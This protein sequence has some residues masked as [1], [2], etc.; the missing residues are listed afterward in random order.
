MNSALPTLSETDE[1][2]ELI[3]RSSAELIAEQG[4]EQATMRVIAAK[5]GVSKGRIEHYFSNKDDVISMA[6]EWV[7][8]RYIERQDR[9]TAGKRGLDAL[10]SRLSCAFPL[11]PVARQE[12]RIRL[13]FWA[14]AGVNPQVRKVLSKRLATVRMR[15]ME[16]LI[17]AR[18]L[19]QLRLDLDTEQTA[20]HLMQLIAGINCHA[21]IDP[22]H[23]S[24][25]HLQELLEKTLTD[26]R[27]RT[28]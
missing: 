14:R 12:W 20:D 22:D 3:A 10:Q 8:R 16:D 23:Y 24:K 9:Q 1:L 11:T 17:E 21:L 19:D 15:F 27:K 4:L 7:N 25:R 13:Q 5:A 28:D 18:E 6:L 2:R 26:L